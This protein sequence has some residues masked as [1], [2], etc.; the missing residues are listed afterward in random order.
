MPEYYT[1]YND[2]YL[3]VHARNL[4]WADSAPSPIVAETMEKHGVGKNAAILE[5]GC[6]EGRD[7]AYL[8]KQGY[9]VLATDVSPEAIR[10]CREQFPD[11][12]EHF[13]VLDCVAGTLDAKFDFIYA[14][15]V[16]HML[17]EDNDRARFYGF[18]RKH[19]NPG[20]AALVCSMG[21]GEMTCRTDPSRAFALQ[22][23]QHSQTGQT[24]SIAATTCRMVSA[25]EFRRE[26]KGSGLR[27]REAGLTESVP[28]FSS[29][30]YAVVDIK[31]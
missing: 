11:Y 23:R 5:L 3:Q 2:R 27:I 21:D 15:A 16:I 4:Q 9:N 31:Q 18:L 19:L 17:V 6:G 1:A 8:L 25:D 7:A 24:L 10:Y 29:M 30:L 26:I 20:G 22:E 13:Q 14:V 12:A 28:G